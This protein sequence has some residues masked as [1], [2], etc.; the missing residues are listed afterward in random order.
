MLNATLV[1][2]IQVTDTLYI[3][4]VK[5][6]EG[7]VDFTPGQYVA[8][9]LFPEHKR[10]DNY[11]PELEEHKPE[12][13]IKRT[14]S[15]ASAPHEKQAYEF[16]L[17]IVPTG[18]LT[19]RL[20]TLEEGDRLFCAKK[21]V[22]KFTTD[23]VP[24]SSNLILICTGTGIAPFIS[25]LRT[26]DTWNEKR[27]ITVLYGARYANDLAYVD[28][29]KDLSLKHP[30][31][32]YY[33][34]VSREGEDYEGTKGYVQRFFEENEVDTNI[35]K[36]HIMVCGNPAMVEDVESLMLARGFKLHSRKLPGNLHLEKYW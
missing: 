21:I 29:L 19:S 13:L 33:T 7:V 36:D 6:D 28:E 24:L 8:I 9:G 11:P 17:A 16:Y 25:M 18:A 23:P 4:H 1:K 2:K 20:I 5:P 26:S 12:K 34:T 30:N 27:K 10:P 15:I 31:F 22:G 35:A 14:Y 3:Y 32:S